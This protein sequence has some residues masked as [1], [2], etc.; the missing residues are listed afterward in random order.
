MVGKTTPDFARITF[1][2]RPVA[3]LDTQILK[4]HTLTVQH[5]ENIMIGHHQQAGR[6]GKRLVLGIPAGIGMAMRGYNRQIF[7]AVIEAAG[8]GAGLRFR[9]Q[10]PIRMKK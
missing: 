6:I 2:R 5:P 3:P 7:D 8:N 10:D 1:N 4:L 9:R